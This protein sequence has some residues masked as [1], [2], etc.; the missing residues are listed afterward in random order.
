MAETQENRQEEAQEEAQEINRHFLKFLREQVAQL[1]QEQLAEEMDV[2]EQIVKHW[3]TGRKPPSQK[4]LVL[5]ERFFGIP[6]G[7]L[8]M[9]FE[10]C[11]IEDFYTAYF[12]HPKAS[13]RIE[14]ATKNLMLGQS[15]RVLPL[16]PKH[17]LRVKH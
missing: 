3:E 13:L 15:L 17:E 11:V 16:H 6:T 9:V 12:E 7:A 4:H 1:T 2:S 5:L 8:A 10:E 14:W